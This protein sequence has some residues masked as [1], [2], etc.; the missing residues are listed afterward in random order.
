MQWSTYRHPI[1]QEELMAYLDGELPAD[2][3][4]EALSHLELCSGVPRP[5]LPIFGVSPKDYWHGELSHR[6]FS[7][8]SSDLNAALGEHLRKRTSGK[9]RF[10]E[11]RR[12]ERSRA[13]G[14]GLWPWQSSAW[15]V[16]T[17][18]TITNRNRDEDRLDSLSEHG[19]DRAIRDARSQCRDCLGAKRCAGSHI[20][21]RK[22]P[23][24]GMAR[25]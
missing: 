11:I 25:L 14:S 19:F 1:E 20:Q 21:G 18:L 4:A 10:A 8:I 3:A 13:A 17:K 15:A 5:L 24:S 23:R 12:T 6:N 22:Y 9:G 2:Q 7:G 16:G